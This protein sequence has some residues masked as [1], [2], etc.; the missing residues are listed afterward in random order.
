MSHTAQER[1]YN[2][3]FVIKAP[4]SLHCITGKPTLE[5]I[6]SKA[7]QAMILAVCQWSPEIYHLRL[8]DC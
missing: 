6:T 1:N 2:S 5:N 8:R 3:E 7:F 4:S